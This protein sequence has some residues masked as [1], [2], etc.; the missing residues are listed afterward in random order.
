MSVKRLLLA[1]G[2]LLVVAGIGLAL[3]VRSVFTGANVRA[4]VERQ[5][6]EAIGQPVSIG[7]IGASAWPRVTMDL[8]DVSIGQPARIRLASIH[9]GTGLRALFSRRIENADVRIDGAR[10]TLPLPP[11]AAD[12]SGQTP[13]TAAAK[14][15]VDIVSIDEIVLKNVEVVSG[16]RI[17]RGDIELVP[18]GAGVQIRR[19]ALAADDTAIQMTGRLTALAPVAGGVEVTAESVDIDRLVAFVNDFAPPSAAPNQARTPAAGPAARPID[20]LTIGLTI[21]RAVTG[22]LALS[23]FTATAVMTSDRVSFEPVA[24][25]IFGGRYDGTMRLELGEIPRFQWKATM[26]GVDTAQLMAFAGSPN[27]ITGTL[28]G[29]VSLEG[30]GLQMEQ[31]LRTAH[32]QARVD[33]ANGTITGLHLVRTIVSA[34]SGR[35]GIVSSAGSALAAPRDA[36]GAERFARLGA[37]LRLRDR[38][39]ETDDVALASTDVDL[40]AAGTL[41]LEGMATQLAGRVQLSEALSK[42]AGTDLFRY[43]QEGGRVTLPVTVSGPIERLAVRIDLAEAAK[44]ALRNRATEEAGKALDRHLPGLGGLLSRRPR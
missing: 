39:I 23:R 8:T 31:A 9:V 3:L 25:G 2:A 44:R 27:T 37:T 43:S 35:G 15:P 26:S 17:L 22:G 40:A 28:G 7:G 1:A 38:V 34:T 6:S 4:A 24:F 36:T 14:P 18:Q 41:R 42:Q 20:Q 12:A 30:D 29:T 32:G 10:L 16:R 21:G 11:L 19:V 13:D 33:I 5:I